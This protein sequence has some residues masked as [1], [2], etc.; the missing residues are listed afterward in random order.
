LATKIDEERTIVTY[1]PE[2]E[3]WYYFSR[4][5][6]LQYVIQQ[7]KQR[8]TNSFFGLDVNLLMS[9][10]APNKKK[11]DIETYTPLTEDSN[12]EINAE[13][14]THTARQAIEIYKASQ[15]VSMYAK[16]I[17][18]YYCYRRL[19]NILFLATYEPTFEKAKGSDTHGLTRDRIEKDNVICKPAGTFSRFQDSYFQDPQVYLEGA[20]FKWQDLL[21][22]PTQGFYMFENMRKDSQ[23]Y[24]TDI[25]KKKKML[26]NNKVEVRESK[27]NNPSYV[28]H[29]LARELLF[30]YAMSMLSRYDILKW[31]ELMDGKYDNIMW[32]IEGYLKT[33]QSFF[34]NLI[35]NEIHGTRYFFFPESRLAP[36]EP[37]F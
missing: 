22:P 29:E 36:A 21:E 27:S 11:L 3:I 8:V 14:I 25:L 26:T 10:K 34:P 2:E 1:N 23:Q 20:S 18:L 13:E 28:I 30:T 6:R 12:L 16:P 9:I 7:L 15:T 37:T 5:T 31:K 19:S 24:I 35:F 33:T 4:L 32:N 17:L